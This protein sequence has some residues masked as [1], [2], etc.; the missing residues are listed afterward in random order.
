VLNDQNSK[1]SEGS[2]LLFPVSADAGVRGG[3]V[4]TR[5]LYGK[6]STAERAEA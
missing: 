5:I 6:A 3:R 2:G 4:P 1:P